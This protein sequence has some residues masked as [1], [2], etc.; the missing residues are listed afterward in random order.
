MAIGIALIVGIRFKENF[1]RPYSSSTITEFWRRWPISLSSWFK[2]YLYIPLGGNRKGTVFT[3]RNLVIVFL[4]TGLW[5]GAAWTYVFW[6][7]MHGAIL[8]G[9]RLFLK[10]SN[11]N[12]P[13]SYVWRFCY[14][15]PLVVT[16]W[17]MFRANSIDQFGTFVSKMYNPF[18]LDLTVPN[19]LLQSM[20]WVSCLIMC[21][22]CLVFI[23]PRD[24]TAASWIHTNKSNEKI[25][26][27]KSI[28]AVG[29]LSLAAM[30]ALVSN[31]SPFL[32]FQ[33]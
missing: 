9:E 1:A 33:F 20:T 4:V 28:Y 18:S 25:L 10:T 27:L 3:Y 16:S 30:L 31:Y 32:Y 15:L 8:I 23:L 13:T 21:L 5:H 7:V 22:A 26:I 24:F 14:V 2:D 12:A 17:A 19:E 6:G 11:G 29:A